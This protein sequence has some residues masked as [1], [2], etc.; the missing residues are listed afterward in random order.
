MSNLA[1][2]HK[3]F[4]SH[5]GADTEENLITL[6]AACHARAHRHKGQKRV[7][8]DTAPKAESTAQN[9]AETVLLASRFLGTSTP[10]GDI[11]N[12]TGSRPHGPWLNHGGQY[13]K[14]GVARAPRLYPH[15]PLLALHRTVQGQIRVAC[16]HPRRWAHSF[17]SSIHWKGLGQ[18]Q[19]VSIF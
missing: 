8:A 18:S 13:L 2:R 11:D 12:E 3:E 17:K 4:R 7:V 19:A 1:L 5:S 6:C 14:T 9:L 10:D 16:L 15:T